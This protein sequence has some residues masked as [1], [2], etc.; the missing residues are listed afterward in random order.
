MK[1]DDDEGLADPVLNRMNLTRSTNKFNNTEA[2]AKA[3]LRDWDQ[4]LL[5]TVFSSRCNGRTRRTAKSGEQWMTYSL[6]ISDDH[7]DLRMFTDM[8]REDDRDEGLSRL[9]CDVA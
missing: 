4:M 5:D 3:Y 9:M 1:I 8:I 6:G 7:L 2:D